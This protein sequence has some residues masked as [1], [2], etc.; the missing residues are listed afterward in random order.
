MT[1]KQF[2]N[3]INKAPNKGLS[4]KYDFSNWNDLE[5]KEF[6]YI[7]KNTFSAYDSI[8]TKI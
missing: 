3:V 7:I 8:E 2:Y 5:K 1:K 4:K 6:D